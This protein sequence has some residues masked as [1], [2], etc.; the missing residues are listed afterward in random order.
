[1]HG[2]ERCV[3]V[4]SG[5]NL[6]GRDHLEYLGTDVRIILKVFFKACDEGMDWTDLTPNR[7]R[8]GSCDCGNEFPD[9]IKSG[10]YLDYL[11]HC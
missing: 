3:G 8:V 1:M 4:F 2:K 9:F 6:R 7:N 10:E 5:G 11:R